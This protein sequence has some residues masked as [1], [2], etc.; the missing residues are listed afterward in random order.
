MSSSYKSTVYIILQG[1]PALYK[2][3][4]TAKYGEMKR[5][6]KRIFPNTLSNLEL[7]FSIS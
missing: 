3:S 6:S 7:K 1:L 5:K 4:S 2:T